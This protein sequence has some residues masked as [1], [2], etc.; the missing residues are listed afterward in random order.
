L[1]LVESR[2]FPSGVILLDY[3]AAELRIEL[4][5]STLAW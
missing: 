2:S 5:T 4:R 1:N 3:T